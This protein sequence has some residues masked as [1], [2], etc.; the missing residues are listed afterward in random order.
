MHSKARAFATVSLG[1]LIDPA[2]TKQTPPLMSSRT[3]KIRQN[4]WEKTSFLF[5]IVNQRDQRNTHRQSA[6]YWMDPRTQP[7]KPQKP[8]KLKGAHNSVH[9]DQPSWHV[10]HWGPP[11]G[12]PAPTPPQRAHQIPQLSQSSP[13][14]KHATAAELRPVQ[15]GSMQ[16][17]RTWEER[18]TAFE[19]GSSPK[20]GLVVLDCNLQQAS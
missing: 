8:T 20:E 18:E 16:T 17:A 9:G 13:G 14:K 15:A 19:A 4:L 11:E 7:D 12:S 6:G 1:P 5:S 3:K 10:L 2:P